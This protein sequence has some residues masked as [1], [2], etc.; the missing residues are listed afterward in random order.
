MISG[1][2]IAL[3]ALELR[4]ASEF[5]R[6]INDPE[7]N[8]WRGLYHP[9]SEVEALKWIERESTPD[10]NH[11]TLA[12]QTLDGCLV[13]II[14]LRG[15]CARSRRA[16]IWVYLGEKKIWQQGFGTDAILTFCNYAFVEMNLHR[17]WLECDPRHRAA[18]RCYE[19][20]GFRIEG[21]LRDAYFRHG[22]FHD[23]VIMGR[24]RTDAGPVG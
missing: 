5:Q 12:I 8:Y 4:D 20:C 3:R 16:E 11:L 1:Q 15:I 10:P 14:G 24:L 23:T 22:G 21:R 13:G 6:W 9:M 2:K 18:I 7:T 17:I 19:K